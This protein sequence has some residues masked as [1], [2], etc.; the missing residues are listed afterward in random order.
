MSNHS[1]APNAELTIVEVDTLK[2]SLAEVSQIAQQAHAAVLEERKRH[3]A[4]IESMRSLQ[5]S[6]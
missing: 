3:V 5:I 2:K 1:V 4:E 6:A